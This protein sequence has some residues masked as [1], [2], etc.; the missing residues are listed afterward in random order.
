MIGRRALLAAGAAFGAGLATRAPAQSFPDRPIR[1]IV[2]FAPGGPVECAENM[3]QGA[4]AGPGRTHYGNGFAAVECEVYAAEHR[5]RGA[6]G[7]VL[8]GNVIDDE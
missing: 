7:R 1:V 6:A 3:K 8:F 5:Q 4:F 2:P